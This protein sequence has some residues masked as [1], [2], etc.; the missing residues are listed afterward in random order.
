MKIIILSTETERFQIYYAN[1]LT[2]EFPQW[3]F[4][5]ILENPV[6]FSSFAAARRKLKT[7]WKKKDWKGL[8]R[9][10][11]YAKID[12]FQEKRKEYE[13]KLFAGAEHFSAETRSIDNHN[14]S[15]SLIEEF[16]PDLIILF[17]ARPLTKKFLSQIKCPVINHHGAILPFFRGLDPEYWLPYYREFDYLGCTIHYVTDQLDEGRILLTRK[18]DLIPGTRIFEIRGMRAELH[19]EMIIDLLKNW[20]RDREN[21]FANKAEGGIYRSFAPWWVQLIA[22]YNLKKREIEIRS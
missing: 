3:S 21:S 15:I 14:H 1:R 13:D 8:I 5:V 7:L 16:D 9:Y 22:A 4:R 11:P 17:G 19:A 6:D 10:F 12:I 18:L 2:R 20:D